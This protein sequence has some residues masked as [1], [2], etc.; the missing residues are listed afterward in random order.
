[1]K[2]I[3]F[4][5]SFHS[6]LRGKSKGPKDVCVQKGWVYVDPVSPVQ[7]G[8]EWRVKGLYPEGRDPDRASFQV[9]PCTSG[10]VISRQSPDTLPI[11]LFSSFSTPNTRAQLGST[12]ASCSS[13]LRFLLVQTFFL[14]HAFLC[15]CSKATTQLKWFAAAKKISQF[16]SLVHSPFL[17]LTHTLASLFS[18]LALFPFFLSLSL[19]FCLNPA[20][21]VLFPAM[22][23]KH[24]KWSNHAGFPF[25]KN[26]RDK[27]R[28]VSSR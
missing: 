13:F 12:Q 3:I 7:P 11:L 2:K 16:S 6:E 22:V 28:G 14:T 20:P 8:R 10:T 24:R 25:Q 9:L 26:M 23:L 4:W 17:S 19:C 21:F 27:A 1:M 18:P 15:V 5:Q